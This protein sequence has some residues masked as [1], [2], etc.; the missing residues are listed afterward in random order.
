MMVLK[1]GLKSPGCRLLRIQLLEDEVDGHIYCIICRAIDS[2]GR[3][4]GVQEWTAQGVQKTSL[5]SLITS[6]RKMSRQLSVWS[7]FTKPNNCAG[8]G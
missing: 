7:L 4:Q 2:E 3:L 1:A 6:Y 5:H 8:G